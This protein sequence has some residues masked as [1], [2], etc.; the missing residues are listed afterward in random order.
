MINIYIFK[1]G[2]KG[3]EGKGS[4]ASIVTYEEAAEITDAA[5]VTEQRR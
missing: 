1:G 2:G 4:Q 3:R 5:E